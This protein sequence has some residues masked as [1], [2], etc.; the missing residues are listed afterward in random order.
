M[1][2][3]Y[4][5]NTLTRKKEIFKSIKKSEVGLYTCGPTVYNFAHIGNLRTYIFEDILNRVLFYNNYKVKRVMNITDVGHL[6]GDQNMGEDKLEKGAKRENRT[7]WEIAEFYTEA[8]KNDFKLLNILEPNIWCKATDYIKEQIDLIK[9]LEKKNYTYK[10][11]DGIYYDTSKFKDYNK[12]SH[13]DLDTLR[14]GARIEINIEKKNPT[15]FALWKFS[16]KDSKRQME[17]GSPWGIGFPGWH[18][19]CS[20]MSLKFL[21]DQLDIHCGGIDLINIHHTNEIAQSEGATGKKFFNYWIHG[22]FLNIEGGKKMAKSEE[23]F[24]TLENAFIKQNIN[25]LVY[26]FLALQVHY[27]KPMEYSQE[28]IKNAQKGLNH[29]YNQVMELGKE[30]GEVDNNFKKKFLEAINDDLNMPQ[31]LGVVQEL[32]KANLVDKDKLKTILDF[33]KVLGLRIE[34]NLMQEKF[35]DQVQKLIDLRKLA[36]DEKEFI[37]SDELRIEI[38]KFG[39]NIEDTKDGQR[40]KKI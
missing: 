9:I 27:R 18:I 16:H 4:F 2:K 10:T 30:K 25:P 12:L 28:G 39:Y 29:L 24:L 3:L 13:L 36:R 33:D 19:E 34:E 26:R 22:A 32:L 7:T 31:V 21:A 5:Y 8:L 15:D 40:V 14:E 35:S 17:W 20:A 1:N 23:N 38:E 37:K 6:T 11:S